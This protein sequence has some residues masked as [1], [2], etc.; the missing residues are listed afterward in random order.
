MFL[1][2]D[3]ISYIYIRIGIKS[4]H[5]RRWDTVSRKQNKTKQR[6]SLFILHQA[7]SSSLPSAIFCVLY[8]FP[9]YPF[10]SALIQIH[11]SIAFWDHFSLQR[12]FTLQWCLTVPPI[13][14]LIMNPLVTLPASFDWTVSDCSRSQDH[15]PGFLFWAGF[16]FRS[17]C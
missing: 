1:N 16:Y 8:F 15:G 6:P 14:Q 7:F 4:D 2:S 13:W 3:H 17:F 5:T 10:L 11:L 12:F 9:K